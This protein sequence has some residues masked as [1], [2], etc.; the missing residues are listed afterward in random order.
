MPDFSTFKWLG[1]SG[2]GHK[3]MRTTKSDTSSPCPSDLVNRQYKAGRP[4]QLWVSDFTYVATW[5]GWLFVA[6]VIDVFARI[7][8]AGIDTSTKC[9]AIHT[10]FPGS[11]GIPPIQ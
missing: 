8:E 7:E 2:Q 9:V 6:F 5:Q 11:F 1:F 10:E 4:N 3:V